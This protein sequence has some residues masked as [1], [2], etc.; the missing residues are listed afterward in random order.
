MNRDNSPF[1]LT[2]FCLFTTSQ[3][4]ILSPIIYWISFNSITRL[5]LNLQ[6]WS[7]VHS[8]VK[9]KLIVFSIV[10]QNFLNRFFFSNLI[11]SRLLKIN[12]SYVYVGA[13]WDFIWESRVAF[14]LCNFSTCWPLR[15]LDDE[16]RPRTS[17]QVI[18]TY[19]PNFCP[20]KGAMDHRH[21]TRHYMPDSFSAGESVMFARSFA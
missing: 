14:S 7:I 3:Q 2:F 10:W 21:D 18:R 19:F 8:H 17:K 15:I 20:L 1:H 4:F 12:I 9:M 11:E 5:N 13:S 6:L 16:R